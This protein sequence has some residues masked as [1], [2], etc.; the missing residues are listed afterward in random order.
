MWVRGRAE[1][2]H[3][4][5]LRV[6]GQ[7]RS[8][9]SSSSTF[10]KSQPQ[11]RLSVYGMPFHAL[12]VQAVC[13]HTETILEL[14]TFEHNWCHTNSFRSYTTYPW[15]VSILFARWS[16]LQT[17]QIHKHKWTCRKK[18]QPICWFQFPK[19]PMRCT[20]VLL[21]LNENEHTRNLCQ[22]KIQIFT[23]LQ[24]N[25]DIYLL[26]LRCTLWKPIFLKNVN[27]VT[28]AQTH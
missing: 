20:R 27:H 14:S 5:T 2:K 3:S 4:L 21:P 8:K 28:Y 7:T 22:I 13:Y 1:Q 25:K 11:Q 17:T 23:N 12:P 18:N 24:M 9:C 15:N 26:A 10:P 16:R 6:F 19:P